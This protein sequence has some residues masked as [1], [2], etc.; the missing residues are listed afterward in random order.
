[1]VIDRESLTAHPWILTMSESKKKANTKPV[2]TV[3][4]GAIA[5]TIWKRQ[6]PSGF[7]YSDFSLSRSRKTQS[8]G[9]EGYS[10]NFFASNL[11][12]L[13]ATVSEAASWIAGQQ[14]SLQAEPANDTH[15]ESPNGSESEKPETNYQ[16]F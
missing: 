10:P 8:T 14:A 16:A 12:D 7:E 13:Q 11:N 1:M 9:R 4:H 6:P 3:R 5:A 2:K 15:P